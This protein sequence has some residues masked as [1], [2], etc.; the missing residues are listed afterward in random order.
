MA[1]LGGARVMGARRRVGGQRVAA[2]RPARAPAAAAPQRLV[3]RAAQMEAGVGVF[4][5]K[6]GMTAVFTD[7]G[8]YVPVTVIKIGDGNIV[9]EKKTRDV[10]GYNSVQVGY[11][12]VDERKLNKPQLGH[13]KKSG[14]PPM[15]HLEEFRLRFKKQVDE[16]E[17]GQQLDI[18]AMFS[19]GDVVDVRGRSVGKGFQGNIKRHGHHRGPMTH[20]SKSH[21]QVGSV[22]PGTT[23]GRV[24]PGRAMPGRMGFDMVKVKS[25]KVMRVSKDSMLVKGSVPGKPGNLVRITPA[26]KVGVN[27]RG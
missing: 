14:A 22:G 18:E 11:D 10:H 17:L 4:G 6:A 26:K 7:E 12:V 16:V 21:R 25:L 13:L 3:V 15:R 1:A 9:T 19:E 23:P 20:G 27:V 5:T 24:F 2:A 8:L